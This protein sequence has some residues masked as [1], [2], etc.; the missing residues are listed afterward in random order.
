MHNKHAQQDDGLFNQKWGYKV[1]GGE[2][3]D[4]LSKKETGFDA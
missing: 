4:A 1:L 3:C 2:A